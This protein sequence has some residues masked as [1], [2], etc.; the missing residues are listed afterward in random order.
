MSQGPQDSRRLGL[1]LALTQ[2][3]MEMVAPIVVGVVVDRYLEWGPWGVVCGAVAGF[4][5]GFIHLLAVLKR[6]EHLKNK[7][8]KAPDER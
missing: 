2:V 1:S 4:V 7:G 6:L 8:P 5:G 3:G